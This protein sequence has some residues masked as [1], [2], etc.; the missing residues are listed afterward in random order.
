MQEPDDDALQAQLAQ[1][2]KEEGL[3]QQKL[4]TQQ[5][6]LLRSRLSGGAVGNV[7]DASMSQQQTLG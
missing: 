4:E 1:Q 7:W 5:L 6:S 3:S 2:K